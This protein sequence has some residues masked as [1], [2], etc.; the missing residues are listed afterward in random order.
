M[1]LSDPSHVPEIVIDPRYVFVVPLTRVDVFATVT[2]M[3]LTLLAMTKSKSSGV[4][5]ANCPSGPVSYTHLTLPTK[6]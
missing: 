4:T 2:T 1:I 3:P 5:S 6:A